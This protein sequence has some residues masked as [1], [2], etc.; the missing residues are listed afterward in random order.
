M[1][2]ATYTSKD[3]NWQ[4]EATI[5][6]FQIDGHDHNSG[7]SFDDDQYGI[8]ESGPGADVV[9][10]DG[11]PV[12]YNESLKLCVQRLCVVTDDMRAD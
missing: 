6:W 11:A 12:D 4:D 8:C 7:L 5:Y 2:K 9:D 10:S 3:Q 1:A